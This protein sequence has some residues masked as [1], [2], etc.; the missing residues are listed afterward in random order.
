MGLQTNKL[1]GPRHCDKKCDYSVLSASLSGHKTEVEWSALG[2]V[3]QNHGFFM[4]F[5]PEKSKKDY[6]IKGV[7]FPQELV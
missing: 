7:F 6:P 4:V 5:P 1:R 2:L 3:P